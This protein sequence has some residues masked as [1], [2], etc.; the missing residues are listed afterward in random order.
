MWSAVRER[1]LLVE[2]AVSVGTVGET[3][4]RRRRTVRLLPPLGADFAELR[5]RAG[6]PPDD[7]LVFPGHDGQ[8]CSPATYKN[9]HRRI[10]RPAIAAAGL[11]RARPYEYA[12]VGITTTCATRSSR[13]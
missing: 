13:S 6:R 5:L 12:D 8:P 4:T 11:D 2:A 7:E 10:F 9:W 1:T 3:K